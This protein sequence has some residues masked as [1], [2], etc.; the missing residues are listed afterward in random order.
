MFR[1]V[2]SLTEASIVSLDARWDDDIGQLRRRCQ[3]DEILCPECRQAVRLR[4]GRI[5][6]RHFAHQSRSD[7]PMSFESPEVLA[8]RAMLYRFLQAAFGDQVS[9]EEPIS[10]GSK[11]RADC[12]VTLETGKAAYFVVPKQIT[13][14]RHAFMERR[15]KAYRHV[16]WVLMPRLL[17]KAPGKNRDFLL[18]TTQRDLATRNGVENIYSAGQ[19]AKKLGSLCYLYE[20]HERL[21]ILRGLECVHQPNVFRMLRG[22]KLDL[23]H[24]VADARTGQLM[25]S[26][27]RD[28]LIEWRKAEE[29]RRQE[30]RKQQL[31]AEARKRER[32]RERAAEIQAMKEATAKARRK[33]AERIAARVA[34]RPAEPYGHKQPEPPPRPRETRALNCLECGQR[35]ANWVYE[36]CEVRL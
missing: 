5:R 9:I 20:K 35:M 15:E 28:A 23:E 34:E 22:L 16:H 31:E 7:C 8:A 18:P 21:I 30:K 13:R 6:R 29:L 26:E 14:E 11:E 19:H 1:A 12:V 27:E 4:A 32:K 36:H 17:K 25:S 33:S 10:K 3:K 2:D 24:V